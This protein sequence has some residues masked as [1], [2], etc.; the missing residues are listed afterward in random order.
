MM[1]KLVL[2]YSFFLFLPITIQT[3]V[4]KRKK[5]LMELDIMSIF[6]KFSHA[7]VSY[8]LFIQS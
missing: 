2:M 5:A 6:F 7:K 8:L 1:K 4:K 3:I